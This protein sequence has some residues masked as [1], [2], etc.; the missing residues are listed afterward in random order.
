MV[1]EW[2]GQT[3]LDLLELWTK[4]EEFEKSMAC[5]LLRVTQPRVDRMIRNRSAAP[6]TAQQVES[7]CELSLIRCAQACFPDRADLRGSQ[8]I[9][10]APAHRSL[11]GPSNRP[12]A[13]LHCECR[14]PAAPRVRLST[15]LDLD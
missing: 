14:P 10:R 5:W 6:A 8:I 13:M 12:T 4:P 1:N 2:P 9:L 3:A 7:R 11:R 15:L